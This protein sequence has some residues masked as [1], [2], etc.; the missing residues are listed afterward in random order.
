MTAIQ[1]AQILSP[2]TGVFDRIRNKRKPKPLNHAGA[3]ATLLVVQEMLD[4][5]DAANAVG[6]TPND[7]VQEAQAWSL[8]QLLG[9]GALND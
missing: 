5:Q 7:L 6:V 3:L 1:I 2:Q 9:T 8:G 4:I